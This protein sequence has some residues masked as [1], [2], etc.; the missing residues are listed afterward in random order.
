MKTGSPE[1]ASTAGAMEQLY[2]QDARTSADG[3]PGRVDVVR[4]AVYDDPLGP[5]QTEDIHADGAVDL[6]GQLS[7][8]VY[9][10]SQE[11]GGRVPFLAIK[12]VVANLVHADFRE[13]VVSLLEHGNVIKVADQG[14]GIPDKALAVEPGFTSAASNTKDMI[15]GVGAGLGVASAALEALGGSLQID[16]N[17]VK[18]TVLT[19][20][21]PESDANAG[22]RA[23]DSPSAPPK[24]STRQ[25]KVLFIIVELGLV[26]PAQ[27]AA[28]LSVGLSTAYRDLQAL[29]R[30]DLI[31]C[32]KQ[33]KRYLTEFGVG[34]LDK[35]ISA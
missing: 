23:D 29:E 35:I 30:L 24:L 14:P 2:C 16:D 4:L 25:K 33:G 34:S 27:M 21:V 17:L 1:T 7:T 18:G 28:E 8:R 13:V 12:E 31:A 26:G 10:L 19:L 5:P 9:Q 11:R 22:S 20:S 6:I 32:D 15:P 3:R